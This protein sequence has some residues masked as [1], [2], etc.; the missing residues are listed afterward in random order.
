MVV[1]LV[2]PFGTCPAGA[3]H[4]ETAAMLHVWTVPTPNGPFA[5]DLDPAWVASVV[6]SG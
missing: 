6:R 5:A 4:V 3:L 2:S 1:G